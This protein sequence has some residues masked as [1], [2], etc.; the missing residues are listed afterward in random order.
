MKTSK[1]TMMKNPKGS[2]KKTGVL[3]LKKFHFLKYKKLFHLLPKT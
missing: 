1:E 3:K 2:P